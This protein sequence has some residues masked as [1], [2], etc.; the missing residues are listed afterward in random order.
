MT[1]CA[2]E[3]GCE[4]ILD[5]TDPGILAAHAIT[6]DDLACPWKDLATRGTRPP[7]WQLAERL[8]A[9]A[10]PGIIVRS[11][12]ARAGAADINVVF[13][14]RAPQPPHQADD[15]SRPPRDDNS[16]R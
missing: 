13:R 2:Y 8:V 15:D 10:A 7:T 11:F 12:A 9:S 6:P 5:Q 1:L 3:I 4:A 16:W 14:D